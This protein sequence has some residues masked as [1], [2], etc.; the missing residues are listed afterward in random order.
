MPPED[1]E[2]AFTTA[3]SQPTAPTQP[4][5]VAQQ[6]STTQT[7]ATPPTS[8][9]SQSP[10]ATPPV[11]PQPAQ[12]AAQPPNPLFEMARQAGFQLGENP[13]ADEIARMAI[14]QV[15][16]LNPMAQY[17][18]QLL[19]HAAEFQKFLEAQQAQQPTPES[20]DEWTPEKYFDGL[21]GSQ[22][23]GRYS[24]AIEQGMVQRDPET[25]MW[26]PVPG[27]EMIVA[28]I[29]PGMNE[30]Q[31]KQTQNWQQITRANPYQHF[32]E[33]LQEPMQ[34]AWRADM[35]KAIQE[36]LSRVKQETVV[37]QFEQQ[38]S[39]W[40][41][42]NQNGQRAYSPHGQK[43]VEAFRTLQDGGIKDQ[44]LL[45]KLAA[46]LAGAPSAPSPAV[47]AVPAVPNPVAASVTQQQSFL[48]NAIQQSGHS[49]G[50]APDPVS[51]VNVQENDLNNMF[52]SAFR[53]SQGQGA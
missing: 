17:A 1:F 16:S 20:P 30:A 25:G 6:P 39:A 38:N 21:W 41:Y 19:P 43:F 7:P 35:Q 42:T 29:L 40:L 53:S 2:S 4:D 36:E 8:P 44:S 49:A 15:Q 33:K 52:V 18:Q 10:P 31:H 23:D 24:T 45:L 14:Q 34:R 13:T 37:E 22:W 47:P 3:A 27:Y 51:P 12:P 50:S 11:A 46:Q 26:A 9:V 5:P 28:G 48:N 32:Y